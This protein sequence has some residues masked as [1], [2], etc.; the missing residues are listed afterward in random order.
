[1]NEKNKLKS[2]FGKPTAARVIPNVPGLK[3][4][5]FELFKEVEDRI[6]ADSKQ[7]DVV[8]EKRQAE[9]VEHD[10]VLRQIMERHERNMTSIAGE[11]K[12]LRES[13]QEAQIMKANLAKIA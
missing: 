8:A 4:K 9:L 12:L 3:A 10:R 11:E 7:L 2:F 13:I 6:E 5:A 1:M